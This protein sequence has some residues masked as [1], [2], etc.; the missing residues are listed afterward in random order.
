MTKDLK[1]KEFNEL[2]A[3]DCKQIK[4]EF[5]PGAFDEFD[6]TQEELDEFIAEIQRLVTSGEILEKSNP[7]DLDELMEEDPE[8]AMKIIQALSPAETK[9]NV[10]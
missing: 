5:A 7:V 3:E 8:Y 1:D 10:Q 4:I 6:G 9:R 2:T